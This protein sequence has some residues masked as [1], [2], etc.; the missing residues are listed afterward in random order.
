MASSEF[1]G[2][3]ICGSVKYC[4]IGEPFAFNHCHC[5]RCR[6][7]TGTGHASNILLKPARADWLA[8]KELLAIYKVPDAQR[9]ASVFCSKCGSP[10]PR[11]AA[12]LGIA[13]IPAGSLDS[14]PP[15]MP[16]GRIFWGSR[17][18]WSCTDDDIPVWEAYPDK[19]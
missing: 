4:I 11:V 6:K 13:V 15:L 3:C 1:Q 16:T 19:S 8:G 9:F 18:P 12:D 7:S 10:M 2:S 5:R 17:A 14:E